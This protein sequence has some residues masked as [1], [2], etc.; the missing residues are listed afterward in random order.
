MQFRAHQSLAIGVAA[1]ILALQLPLA[2]AADPVADFYKGKT[3]TILVPIGPGGT[4]D[5]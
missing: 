5:L 2:A 4:Y 3:V 1:S